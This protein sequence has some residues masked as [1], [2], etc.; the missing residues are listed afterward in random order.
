MAASR[1]PFALAG[2][3]PSG[4]TAP[5]P[6]AATYFSGSGGLNVDFDQTLDTAFSL[7]TSKWSGC[8]GTV[9]LHFSGGSALGNQC[10]F[11][12]SASGSPCGTPRISYAGGD[13]GLRAVGGGPVVEPFTD[14]PLTV[15]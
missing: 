3:P 7:D 6:I 9:P 15:V 10:T 11:V 1:L 13:A 14:F 12:T 4:P 5:I 8:N 2:L